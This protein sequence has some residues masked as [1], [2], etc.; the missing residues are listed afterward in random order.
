MYH[1]IVT[2]ATKG[3]GRAIA[4]SLVEKGHKLAICARS[5]R[6]L[7]KTQ[8]ELLAINPDTEVLIKCADLEKKEDVLSFAQM[9]F[10]HWTKVDVLINNAGIFIPG[11][12]CAEPS[13]RLEKMMRVNL[14]SAY[15]LTRAVVPTMIRQ[16]F[17]YIINMCSVA[18]LYA[19]PNGG[20]YS[21][22]K[23]ALLG[24]S[25]VL[26]EELK[27]KG[28]KVSS[29]LPGATW[30]NSWAGVELPESRLMQASDVAK[31]VNT[32]LELSGSA[33]LEDVVLRPQLGDL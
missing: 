24:F 5:R 4:D 10:E 14:Y 18:S 19:Y 30:S 28:I 29:I 22:S 17:G 9:V 1:I 12:L 7:E 21:I 26:R 31:V 13:D 25:K 33:V 3:I 8:E 15:H 23:F 2:G 11:E 27:D 6:D 16:Q 20:S 32:I